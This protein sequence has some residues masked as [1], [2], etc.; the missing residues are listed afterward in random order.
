MMQGLR[1]KTKL[2]MII[3]ALAFVGLMVFD[4]GMDISG[5]S[6][7]QQTGE[8]GRVN[9][10]P[11]SAQA[12]S[13]AYQQLYEQ[14]R[15]SAGGTQLSR[16]QIRQLENQA[17]EQVVNELL[18]DQELRR[19]GIRVSDQEIVQ[20]A[21]WMPHPDLM[22]NELFLTN[23]EFDINKY[24]QFISGP[25]ANE[26]LLL[27]LEQYYRTTIPR[28][29]LM[30]QVTAG[31]YV[32]DSNLWQMWRDQTERASVDYVALSPAILVPGDV[33]VSDDEISDYYDENEELFERAAS[34]RFR[35][36][37]LSKA[38][39]AVDSATAYQTALAL[40]QEI[41]DGADFAVVAQRES[42][43]V[44]SRA[45]G[46]DLGTFGR[47]QMNPAFEEAAF[48]LPLGEISPAIRT[49]YG[50]H[51]IEVLARSETTVNARH[52]LVSFA[53]SDVS[54]DAL[55]MQADSLEAVAERAGV[56]RGAQAVGAV[57]QE[58]VVVSMDDPY[59]PGVGSAIEA[60]EW[61]RDEQLAEDPLQVSP[62]FETP[63]SFYVVEVEAYAAAGITPLEEATPEIRRQLIVDKKSEQ[64][65][66]IGE[67][68]V[69]EVR[70]GKTLE[71]AAQERGLTV[72]SV[73][74]ITRAGFN[75]AFGQANAA[76]G[77]AF[78]VAIGQIS[79]VVSTPTG[80]F[81]VRPRERTTANRQE[82]DTQKETL[83][84]LALFQVQQDVVSR[85]M[86]DLREESEIVDRRDEV[87]EAQLLAPPPPPL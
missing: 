25:S 59:V 66:T 47:G 73:D 46:G 84:Q 3:V 2:V 78:G 87:R 45:T 76:T 28:S 21:R 63:E 5:S 4:W 70:A 85:W 81:I 62:V 11:V 38:A 44:A 80:Y 32:S 68:I 15:L 1:E 86:E 69:S 64:A 35:I 77:A 27:T 55:Y 79:D 43:D 37:Y 22:Q 20:A 39:T 16:D 29:K 83:R 74:S 71:Q 33:A 60:I 61:A 17:F 72:Q 31:V 34:A 51:L 42:D 23:G 6:V 36:A 75:P 13:L 49:D 14:A 56:A 30:R 57:L 24:Q 7:A 58:G 18:I 54:L 19:R 40:R 48:T 41:L 50:Y 67:Q 9:G 10:E 12:Y 26:D 82:F 65:R 8:L 53:P 52:I